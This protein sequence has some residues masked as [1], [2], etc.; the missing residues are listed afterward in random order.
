MKA[1]TSGAF[2]AFSGTYGGFP[3]FSGSGKS[4]NELLKEKDPGSNVDKGNK[5]QGNQL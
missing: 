3:A 4:F 5:D 1:P 2:S